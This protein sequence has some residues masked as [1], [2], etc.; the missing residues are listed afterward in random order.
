MAALKYSAK[1]Y[2]I[3]SDIR[4]QQE[5]DEEE[6]KLLDEQIGIFETTC[7]AKIAEIPK[8]FNQQRHHLNAVERAAAEMAVN[9]DIIE[10][11]IHKMAYS[12]EK[13]PALLKLQQQEFR[14]L[15][16]DMLQ[17]SFVFCQSSRQYTDDVKVEVE[18]LLARHRGEIQG[19]KTRSGI[20]ESRLQDLELRE[21]LTATQAGGGGASVRHRRRQVGSSRK[22]CKSRNQSPASS[23]KGHGQGSSIRNPSPA[24]SGAGS[25]PPRD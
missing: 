8:K 21:R 5:A 15:M 23:T 20:I 12:F 6:E 1:P 9:A 4:K 25:C 13:R 10:I 2:L 17:A 24:V 14:R 11:Q 18:S 19:L 16:T 3:E 7:V 22:G